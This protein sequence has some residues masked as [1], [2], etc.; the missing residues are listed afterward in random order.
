MELLV[1][2]LSPWLEKLPF[3][4]QDIEPFGQRMDCEKHHV[5]FRQEEKADAIYIVK[6]GRVRLFL[7]SEDGREKALTI[8]GQ[9][10]LL[11]ECGISSSEN[12][13]TGAITAAPS[14]I[15]KYPI[16]QFEE[17]LLEDKKKMKQWMELTNLKMNILTKSS[18][19]LSFGP[20]RRRIIES[21][22]HLALTFGRQD[23]EKSYIISITFT[24]QELADLVGTT[25]VTVVNT[26]NKL[27]DE[28]FLLKKEKYYEIPDIYSLA[29]H[30]KIP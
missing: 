21:L 30:S 27:I 8:I 14:T 24:H 26:L 6:K 19:Q 17:M 22:L 15:L 25:R 10:G 12:Y 11:G 1:E 29:N 2:S 3:D 13:L 16:R 23:G 9:N 7:T 28:G 4:W 5:I 18:L 20:S